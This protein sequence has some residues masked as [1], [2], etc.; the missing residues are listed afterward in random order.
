MPLVLDHPESRRRLLAHINDRRDDLHR[1]LAAIGT[2][3]RK[4]DELRGRLAELKSI[5][6]DITNEGANE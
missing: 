1:R 5:E 3:E 4:S 2:D 6:N